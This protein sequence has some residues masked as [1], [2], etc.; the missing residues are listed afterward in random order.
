MARGQ[1]AGAIL[2]I[3]LLNQLE[4]VMRT[5][6]IGAAVSNAGCF[7]TESHGPNIRQ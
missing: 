4:M 2:R 6:P 1:F 5:K 7:K 3:N